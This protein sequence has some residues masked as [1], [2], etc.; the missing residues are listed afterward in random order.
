MGCTLAATK[1]SLP[2]DDGYRGNQR[3]KIS[4]HTLVNDISMENIS[5]NT[6]HSEEQL[7]KQLDLSKRQK[8]LILKSWKGISRE[9]KTTAVNMFS[10]LFETN[11]ELKPYFVDVSK[12]PTISD[13]R[14][15]SKLE[16]HAVMVM[17]IIDDAMSNFD[18]IT[19]IE[20]LLLNVGESHRKFSWFKSN[21][22]W[23][24]EEP[25]LLAVR[26]TLGD[27]YTSNMETTYMKAIHFILSLLEIGFKRKT[28]PPD[29][30]Q[31][32][33]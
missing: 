15:S 18:D 6:S 4:R 24:L 26:E 22:F 14:T 3:F 2:G 28:T 5:R 20:G 33:F 10:R 8:F 16:G 23:K 1:Q 21:Y 31:A 9:I 29:S 19:S 30:P 12:C 13:I 7:E 25:F 17:N 27:R 11:E 32:P